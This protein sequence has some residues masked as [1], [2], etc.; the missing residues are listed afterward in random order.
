LSQNWALNFFICQK[1][2]DFKKRSSF[3]ASFLFFNFFL[4][5]FYNVKCTVN[6]SLTFFFFTFR[7]KKMVF[8]GNFDHRNFFLTTQKR[9]VFTIS[10]FF[11][12]FL[13]LSFSIVFFVIFSK[14]LCKKAATFLV[15]F[16]KKP[17][18]GGF[19]V[20]ALCYPILAAFFRLFGPKQC[21]N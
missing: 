3:Y 13:K 2:C 10:V 12:F 14:K 11:Y 4:T 20:F 15:F 21:E 1:A 19:W 6:F 17:S 16:Q 7:T 5:P 8:F 18:R 9:G